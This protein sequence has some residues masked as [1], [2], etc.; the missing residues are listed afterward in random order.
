[1]KT[2]LVLTAIGIIG[3]ITGIK[4][5]KKMENKTINELQEEMRGLKAERDYF[6]SMYK[7]V[8]EE[9]YQEGI[10]QETQ[11]N[12]LKK[13]IEKLKEHLKTVNFYKTVDELLTEDE[14]KFTM[15]IKEIFPEE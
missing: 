9:G 12:R 15:D 7:A 14:N 13:E 2:I 10:R 5:R 1:M 6:E 3:I 8:S 11:I 4:I